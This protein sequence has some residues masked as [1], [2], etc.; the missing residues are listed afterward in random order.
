M[1]TLA[2]LI[3]VAGLLACS[4]S[5]QGRVSIRLALD[6]ERAA[7]GECVE[8][9]VLISAT[10]DVAIPIFEPLTDSL[11]LGVKR[12]PRRRDVPRTTRLLLLRKDEV[13]RYVIPGT[14]SSAEDGLLID[15][16]EFGRVTVLEGI[17]DYVSAGLLRADHPPWYS[18]DSYES[19]RITI[20]NLENQVVEF[21]ARPSR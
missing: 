20:N 16:G 4:R 12:S 3:S 14:V 17:G 18:D 6:R 8:V 9:A 10:C 19:E 2:L 1:K 15:F 5:D 13:V 11:S 21:V 7:I